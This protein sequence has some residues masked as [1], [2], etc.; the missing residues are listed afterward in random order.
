MHDDYASKVYENSTEVVT[1]GVQESIT[2][3]RALQLA[4]NDYPH[5]LLSHMIV[6]AKDEGLPMSTS[7]FTIYYNGLCATILVSFLDPESID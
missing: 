2:P 7:T 5:Y 1:M 6:T 3:E 4:K